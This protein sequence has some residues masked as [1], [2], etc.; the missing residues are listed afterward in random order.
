MNAIILAAGQG[1]RLN[2]SKPKCLLVFND[3]TLIE[4]TLKILKNN[5]GINDIRIVI[6]Y[7]GVWTEKYRAEIMIIARKYNSCVVINKQSMESQSI[8][9]M[10]VGIES[11]SVLGDTLVIDGDLVFEEKIINEISKQNV[12]SLVVS[13]SSNKGS[14]VKFKLRNNETYVLEKIAESIKSKYV[15]N[16]IMMINKL[17]M[18]IFNDLIQK[19]DYKNIIMAQILDD[20]SNL[21]TIICILVTSKDSNYCLNSHIININTKK[22]LDIAK[23]LF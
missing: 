8:E 6:G 3:E 19:K 17:D 14:K 11:F 13:E 4:R 23:R 18:K 7:G 20:L 9:S 21:I 2:I 1:S 10:R 15:Y 5:P 22:D 12:S 16:G